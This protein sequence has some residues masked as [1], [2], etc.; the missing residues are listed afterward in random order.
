MSLLAI[1]RDSARHRG[2]KLAG[3]A[4]LA[5]LAIIIPFFFGPYRVSQFTLVIIYAVAVL[6]LNLLV[7]YSGQI[8][9]GHGAFFCL[10]A[11]TAAILL[12]KTSIPYLL[13]VPAAGLVCFVAGLALGLPALRLRGL[14][15]ALV[16]LAIAIATPVLI[17]RFDSL[18]GGS[19]GLTVAQPKSP[20]WLGLADDQFLYFLSAVIAAPMFWFAAGVVRR[21]VGRALIAMRDDEIAARTMGVNLATF[22]TRAFGLSAAFAGVAGALFT[23]ANGF[24][25][26]ESF[27]LTVSF[28]FLAAIVVGGLATVAGALFG[29]LFIVF[30]PV[31][32]S[33][34]DEALSGVIYGATLIACMYVFRGGI[35]GLLRSAWRRLVEV[36]GSTTG[37][38]EDEVDEEV[39]VGSADRRAGAGAGGVRS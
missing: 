18:T 38:S 8:S 21:N 32:S 34:V 36:Q 39:V 14:Y 25:A 1:E 3:L 16:T 20:A 26:P 24:V 10:G 5:V 29:A 6:G 2:L 23:F 22:K 4:G 13:T 31:W 33:D 17:K 37:R 11:Y 28:A 7:G 30:V 27:A 9:L 12:N 15:L 35:M 19:Q